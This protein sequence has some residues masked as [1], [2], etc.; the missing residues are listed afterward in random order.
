MMD[1]WYRLVDLVLPFEWTSH[2][3]MK[4]A[5]LAVLLFSPLFGLLGTMIV[6]NRMAFFSDALGHGAFTGIAIGGLM[7]LMDRS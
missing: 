5:L 7:G 1:A 3:F 6:S 2:I 4:N